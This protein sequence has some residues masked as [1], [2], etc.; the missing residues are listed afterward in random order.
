MNMESAASAKQF[1]EV[2]NE[3]G[4]GSLGLNRAGELAG[5]GEDGD[6]KFTFEYLGFLFA[7]RAAASEQ[8][9]N[10][11]FHANLGNMPYTGESAERRRDAMNILWFA[12]AKLGGRVRMTPEQRILLTEEFWLDEPLTPTA[13]MTC[14]AKLLLKAKPYLELLIAVVSPPAR[15]ADGVPESID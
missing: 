14:A 11:R 8:R 10:V 15:V 3:V 9:T 4:S 13:L 5:K 2:A 6:I 7:V 1:I 12:A